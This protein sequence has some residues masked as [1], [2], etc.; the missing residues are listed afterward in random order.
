MKQL[1]VAPVFSD[2]MVL[3]RDKNINVW[4][5]ASD[6]DRITVAIEDCSA[7]TT[8]KNNKW[9]VV[10]PGLKAGGPYDVKV[11]GSKDSVTFSNVMIGEVW[12]AGGQSN[13]EFE[14]RNSK[15]GKN[16]AAN[17][18]GCN[19]RYYNPL[20][21]S[22][23]D[24]EFLK[25]EEETS[26]QECSPETVG[27]WSAAAFYF[28]KKLSEELNVT[29]GIINCNWGGTSASSWVNR[30]TL[31]LDRDTNTYVEEYNK[32]NEGRT[33]EEYLKELKDYNIWYDAWQKRVDK[34][35]AEDPDMS[36]PEVLK[37]AGESRWPEPLGPKSPYRPAG[38]YETML[39]RVTPYTLRGFIYY[40]GESDEHKPKI[41]GK[42]FS[43]L[44][45]QWRID[46][47][48]DELP[49]IFVQLPMYIGKGEEDKKNWPIIRE[50]QMKVHKTVK[51]TGIAVILDCGEYGNLHPVDKEPVGDRLALQALYH[52]Y[53][54]SADAYGPIYKG[55]KYIDNC[56]ELSFDHVKDGFVVKGDKAAGFEIAGDDRKFV[57]AD[58][59]IRADKIVVSAENIPDPK[60]VRYAWFNYAQVTLFN[61][62]GL[63]LAPFRTS[64][65]DE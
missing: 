15:N 42:L 38:L 20:K 52:V 12:L 31:E 45:D 2:N 3:Q 55:L 58:I 27:R 37:I 57:P 25:K 41:Y 40:Q 36:W 9:T 64:R 60:Y 65:N 33:F 32:A 24:E 51:N 63:P 10:L 16:V 62:A 5:T 39:Q 18:K 47:E 35:Y 61:K 54:K 29:I 4:G 11:T 59:D 48:D 26:W 1:K 50:A 23:I 34:C 44:I 56:I 19:I 43:K 7:S 13:M 21:L 53:G 49:F 22:Y 17:V 30:E 8:V 28:A 14:L 46:W 6:G